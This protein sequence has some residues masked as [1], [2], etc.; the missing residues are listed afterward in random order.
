MLKIGPFSLHR[1]QLPCDD[2][3]VEDIMEGVSNRKASSEQNS[4]AG[5]PTYFENDHMQAYQELKLTYPP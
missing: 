5:G 2:G 1:F 3:I 4:S